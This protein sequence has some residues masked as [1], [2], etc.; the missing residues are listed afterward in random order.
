MVGERSQSLPIDQNEEFSICSSFCENQAHHW[1]HIRTLS[2][3][4]PQW[5]ESNVE[6]SS[7]TWMETWVK[8]GNS[9]DYCQQF[10][11]PWHS[12]SFERPF[13]STV[14]LLRG[15]FWNDI[16][17]NDRTPVVR[18]GLEKSNS[19][20]C[21]RQ[22]KCRQS[23]QT[24]TLDGQ[25]INYSKY[26]FHFQTGTFPLMMMRPSLLVYVLSRQVSFVRDPFCFQQTHFSIFREWEGK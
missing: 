1:T 20:K 18:R 19:F 21:S 15:W 22:L 13:F 5:D 8:Y 16:F 9:L 12:I 17:E 14:G 11:V 6:P 26:L 23:C 2:N 7:L 3:E 4:W 24:W 25:R 10:I